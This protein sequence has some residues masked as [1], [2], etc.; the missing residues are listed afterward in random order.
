MA[1]DPLRNLTKLEVLALFNNE[2]LNDRRVLDVLDKLINLKELS[3][4][5]NPVSYFTFIA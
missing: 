3:I 4:D 2:I 1:I 5:G